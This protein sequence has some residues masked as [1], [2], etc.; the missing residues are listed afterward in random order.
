MQYNGGSSVD[1]IQF[2][3][4]G[5]QL[6]SDANVVAIQNRTMVMLKAHTWYRKDRE[7]AKM[8]VYINKI[9]IL[10]A[11]TIVKY[12]MSAMKPILRSSWFAAV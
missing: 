5:Q 11:P 12:R 9:D 1:S 2:H 10:V 8:R 7:I 3:C 6:K 4:S